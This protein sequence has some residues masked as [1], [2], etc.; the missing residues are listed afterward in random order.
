MS[1]NVTLVLTTKK[2]W[3]MTYNPSF[4]KYSDFHTFDFGTTNDI[5]E[6]GQNLYEQFRELI[7]ENASTKR[8]YLKELHEM[9]SS[10]DLWEDIELA[11]KENLHYRI[12]GY[13]V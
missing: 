2:I 8:R 11:M 10:T 1:T 13:V 4:P 5:T 6:S 12:Y 9:S 7:G 3:E